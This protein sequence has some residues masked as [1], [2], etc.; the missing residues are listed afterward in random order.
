MATDYGSHVLATCR[1]ASRLT[2]G[3]NRPDQKVAIK[4]GYQGAYL[5]ECRRIEARL[6]RKA[7]HRGR[8]GY[9]SSHNVGVLQ[10]HPRCQLPPVRTT[11]SD[12]RTGNRA[13][14]GQAAR[15][16]GEE[17]LEFANSILGKPLV[18]APQWPDQLSR[19]AHVSLSKVGHANNGRAR[20]S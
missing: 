7:Q 6:V 13:E 9:G 11:K 3:C 20:T 14:G 17:S 8:G 1:K 19:L 16:G 2:T 12:D 18:R 4:E 5:P 10:P 15:A